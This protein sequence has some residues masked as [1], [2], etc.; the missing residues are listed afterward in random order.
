MLK[1][2]LTIQGL[3]TAIVTLEL[4]RAPRLLPAEPE[5]ARMLQEPES[6]LPGAAGGIQGREESMEQFTSS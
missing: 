4:R 2:F 3:L 6:A 1:S 5:E